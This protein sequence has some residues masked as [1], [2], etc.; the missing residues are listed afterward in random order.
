MVAQS[1]TDLIGGDPDDV[2]HVSA[3]TGQGVEAVL[4]RIVERVPAPAGDPDAPLQ[5]LIF[6]STFDTYRG[7]IVYVRVKEG[8]LRKGDAIE[9]MAT[10][11]TYNAE[12]IGHLKL[13]WS[14]SRSSGRARSATSSARSRTWPIRRSA[15]R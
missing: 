2:L 13:G 6:D 14:P 10:N 3:K 1:I 8:T 9:F 11:A 12:E 4:E 7:S 15:T 5:A